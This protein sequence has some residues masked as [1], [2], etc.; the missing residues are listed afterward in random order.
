[1]Y[2][3]QIEAGLA[4][5]ELHPNKVKR[6]LGRELVTIYHSAQDAAAAEEAFDKLFK[7]HALPEDIEE[8][9]VELVDDEEKGGVFLPPVLVA[10]KLAGTNG[11]ARRLIDGGGVKVNGEALAAK[12]YNV[13]A[14]QLAGAVLQV[15][16][17]KFAR[18]A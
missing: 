6:Q 12:T 8:F 13:P 2:K 3:R 17:R 9:S 15:G 14:A 11:E 18:L 7:E 10:C 1:M 5:G 16:K 4:S